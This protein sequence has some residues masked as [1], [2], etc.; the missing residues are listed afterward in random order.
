MVKVKVFSIPCVI[1]LLAV[2]VPLSFSQE[3]KPMHAPNTL[4][5]VDPEMLTPGYWAS[6]QKDADAV[7][8]SPEEIERFNDNVRKKRVVFRDYYGKE[9]P[10]KNN[11]ISS[12]ANGL[13]MNPLQPLDLRDTIPGDSLRIRFAKNSELLY[14]PTPLY[15]SPDFYDG[16]LA[17][18]DTR[19]KDEVFEKMNMNNIPAVI[20]PRFGIIINHALVRQYPTPVPG[21][22][23]NRSMLDRFQLTDLCIGNPVAVLHNSVDGDYL[24][25]ECPLARGW[26]AAGDV[27]FADRNTIRKLVEDK[28][29]LM[30]TAHRVP[31]YGDPGYKN[32]ARH[33]YF[34]ATMPLISHDSNGY[35]VKMP[36]RESDGSLGVDT[37]YI[38]PDADVHIGYLPYTKRNVLIQIFK[39]LNTPYGWHGQDNKRDCAG[40]MRVLLRCFGIKA[41]KNPAFI[42]SASDNQ[43]RMNPG[44]STEEKMAEA[45]KLEPVITMAGN[46][47]HISLFLGKARNGKL[48]YIHQAGWGYKDDNGIQR[49]V[50]RVTVNCAEHGFYSIHGPNVYTTMNTP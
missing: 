23:D 36:F 40:T 21:Y 2:L 39:L 44:L 38:K 9:D 42:L 5:G 46:S 11:F 7:I 8:L 17:I 27:A 45:S 48:Y 6:L 18:Y 37:G 32:F 28:N 14:S 43:F 20:R 25:V 49:I 13:V 29:F 22:H 34:S 19:M 1:I 10:L 24:F 15:G 26:I 16:R 47:G 12:T 4:P 30:A 31:V 35:K 50:G 41:G 3:S 33:F